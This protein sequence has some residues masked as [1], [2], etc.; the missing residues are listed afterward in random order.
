MA[1]TEDMPRAIRV[2]SL[3][4][5]EACQHL[6]EPVCRPDAAQCRG[7]TYGHASLKLTVACQHRQAS[8]HGCEDAFEGLDTCT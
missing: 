1:T 3:L 5:C 8:P 4:G 6:F 2:Y 7:L